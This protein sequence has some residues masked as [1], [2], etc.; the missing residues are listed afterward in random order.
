MTILDTI[1]ICNNKGDHWDSLLINKKGKDIERLFH[2][3][4]S[5]D[6]FWFT[7]PYMNSITHPLMPFFVFP[8]IILKWNINSV[9]F[10]KFS[11]F[12]KCKYW[13]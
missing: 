2:A 9:D 4:L 13:V 7:S 12:Q 5:K 10:E 3:K 6:D 8:N 1:L 11:H